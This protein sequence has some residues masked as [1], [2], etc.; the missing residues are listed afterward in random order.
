MEFYKRSVNDL[1]Q[2]IE[3]HDNSWIKASIRKMK[4]EISEEGESSILEEIY[5]DTEGE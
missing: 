3:K 2:K 1:Y 4:E 5:E